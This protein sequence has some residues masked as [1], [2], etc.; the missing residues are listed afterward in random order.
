MRDLF[1]AG[2]V[3]LALLAASCGD[4]D[5]TITPSDS[6]P[7]N[8]VVTPPTPPGTD[9]GPEDNGVQ[10]DETFSGECVE[11]PRC[12]AGELESACLCLPPPPESTVARTR[13][14]A[15]Q[16]EENPSPTPSRD[17]CDDGSTPG[18]VNVSCYMPGSYFETGPSMNV[19]IFGIVDVFGN[20]GDANDIEVTVYR[21][22]P[23]GDLGEMVGT[24][25]ADTA[26][27]MAETE[28]LYEDGEQTGERNLGYYEIANV[29]TETPLIVHTSGNLEFWKDLYTYNTFIRN[30]TV[31]GGR[32]EFRARIL[33]RADYRSI[34]STAG[35]PAGITIGNGAVAGEVHDCD[36]VR[37]SYVQVAASPSP[38]V[39]TYFNDNP[40]NPLPDVGRRDGTSLLGLYSALDIPPGPVDIAAV[41]NV[42][43]VGV[44]SFGWYRARIFPNAITVVTLRG[45]RPSQI[46]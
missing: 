41:G 10:F 38:Q 42:D 35:L 12:S 29:P 40:A 43:G 1:R 23:D 24:A 4:D 34:P 16:N 11:N 20:G 27:P 14:S 30:A 33:S 25:T 8:D 2:S 26:H 7:G 46:E 6:G 22:G 17:F 3:V 18:P 45:L 9:G 32:W 37:L 44:V 36:D 31:E 13:C 19:T 15:F 5:G 28:I 39:L 21:E